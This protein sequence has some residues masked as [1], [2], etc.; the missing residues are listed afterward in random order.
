MNLNEHS[1]WLKFI[2]AMVSEVLE[3]IMRYEENFEA[4]EQY[5]EALASF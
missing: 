1:V 2:F 5:F 3:K 4:L